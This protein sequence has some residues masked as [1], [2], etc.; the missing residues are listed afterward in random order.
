MSVEERPGS[1]SP[2]PRGTSNQARWEEVLTVAAAVFSEKGYS[3]ATLQDIAS[4]LGMLKGSLYYYIDSKEDLLFEILRRAHQQG[5]QYVQENEEAASADPP[6][7]LAFLIRRW[8]QGLESLPAEL[9]VAEHDFRYL[10]GERR[11]EIMALR[12]R[13]A[14][15]PTQIIVAGIRDGSFDPS[16]DAYAATSTLFRVLNTTGQWYRPGGR[17][18]WEAV[19][20]WIVHLFL[21]GLAAGGP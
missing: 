2:R 10:E 7:R 6:T 19:T 13:I 14:A 18:T 9:R 12:A 17:T 3:S 11:A 16:V 8:M 21:G 4:Q 15:V 20:D 5:V 1:A